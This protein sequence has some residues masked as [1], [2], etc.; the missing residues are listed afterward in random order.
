MSEY[1]NLKP[2]YASSIMRIS[3]KESKLKF[4]NTITYDYFDLEK[5][6]IWKNYQEFLKKPPNY[7]AELQLYWNNFQTILDEEINKINEE[8]VLLKVIHCTILFRDN[9][10]PYVQW[11]VEFEGNSVDGQNF[12]QNYVDEEILEYP[13]YSL[14][15]FEKP[16]V[17]KKIVTSLQYN[18]SRSNRIIEYF[19]EPNNKLDGYEAIFFQ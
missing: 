15:I 5:D 19:G 9:F 6:T 12:Y 11:I 8:E 18:I 13:I 1:Q 3:K 4:S 2:I 17:V 14:Y 10:H 16:L 7:E